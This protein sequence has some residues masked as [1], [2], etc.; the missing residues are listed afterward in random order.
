MELIG[1]VVMSNINLGLLKKNIYKTYFSDGVWDIVLGLIYLSFGLGIM[2]NQNF[3]FAFPILMTLPLALKRSLT[4]PRI[5]ALK[6]KKSQK[7]KLLLLYFLFNILALGFIFI[8]G[9]LNPSSN[10]LVRWMTFN[11]FLVLGL[12]IAITFSLV[13]KYFHFERLYL[14]AILTFLGFALIGKLTSA[15]VVLTILGS[16]IALIGVIVLRNF[17][18][19]HPKSAISSPNDQTGVN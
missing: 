13:A 8:V 4:E 16:I 11:I 9:I 19:F 5:G 12:I 6:F 15:G 10:G 17:I 2:V 14:Y 7:N 1:E 18:K 3:I